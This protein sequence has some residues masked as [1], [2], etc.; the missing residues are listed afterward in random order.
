MSADRSIRGDSWWSGIRAL[1]SH[2]RQNRVVAS[3]CARASWTGRRSGQPLG[4]GQGAKQLLALD[5]HVPRADPVFLDPQQQIG[6]EPDGLAGARRVGAVAVVGQLPVGRCATVVKRR[7]AHEVYLDFAVQTGDGAHEHVLSVL[8][9]G[10]AGVWGDRVLA[11]PRP[12]Y[13]CIAGHRPAGGSTPR[14]HQRVGAGLI[15]PGARH[16]DPERGQPK[17]PRPA[18]QQRPEDARGV[19][20]GHA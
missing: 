15:G 4:P 20:P 9:A 12:H 16:V 6:I 5:Q 17:R 10:R 14:G 3:N 19:K 8:V 2:R 11:R 18:V 1:P 7:L 13:E